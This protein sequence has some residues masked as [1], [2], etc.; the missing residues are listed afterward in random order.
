MIV[1]SAGVWLGSPSSLYT[2][3]NDVEQLLRPVHCRLEF[4]FDHAEPATQ[5]VDAEYEVE[6]LVFSALSVLAILNHP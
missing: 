6:S 2:R 1:G 5:L 4:G 3:L